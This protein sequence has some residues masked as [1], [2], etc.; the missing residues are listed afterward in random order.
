MLRKW[1]CMFLGMGVSEVDPGQDVARGNEW[2]EPLQ[3]DSKWWE[4]M[5]NIVDEVWVSA[6]EHEIFLDGLREFGKRF[7]QGWVAGG[8]LERK[9]QFEIEPNAAHIGPILDVMLQSSEKGATQSDL[10]EW[11]VSRLVSIRDYSLQ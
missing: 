9:V 3:A 7:T 1:A 5:H 10:E 2:S 11:L 8:G 6:G 4:G